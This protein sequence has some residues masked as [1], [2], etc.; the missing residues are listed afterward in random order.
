MAT[1]TERGYTHQNGEYL[2]LTSEQLVLNKLPFKDKAIIRKGYFPESANG[3][4]NTKYF[5]VNVDFD[6]YNPILAGLRFFVP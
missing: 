5:F 2:S 4:E 1:D 6:L 3:L